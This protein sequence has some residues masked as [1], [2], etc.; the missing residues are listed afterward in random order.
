MR[1]RSEMHNDNDFKSDQGDH[2]GP[3]NEPG[4]LCPGRVKIYNDKL[5][6]TGKQ[7]LKCD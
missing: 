1:K 6:G 3:V 4:C 2:P 5:A 7:T